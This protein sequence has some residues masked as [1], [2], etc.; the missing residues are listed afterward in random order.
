MQQHIGR[1]GRVRAGE[2]AN[3]RIKTKHGLDRVGLEPGIEH[4]AG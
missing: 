4:I 2:V 1:T 3:H